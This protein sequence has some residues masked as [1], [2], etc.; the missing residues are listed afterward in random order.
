MCKSPGVEIQIVHLEVREESSVGK[1]GG[2]K[3]GVLCKWLCLPSW[4]YWGYGV[5]TADG[6][7]VMPSWPCLQ[8][9]TVDF[10]C[11]SYEARWFGCVWAGESAPDWEEEAAGTCRRVGTARFLTW[12]RP[13]SKFRSWALWEPRGGGVWATQLK[14]PENLGVEALDLDSG[15]DN[16]NIVLE[17]PLSAALQVTVRNLGGWDKCVWRG[18][19]EKWSFGRGYF[20]RLL[21][22]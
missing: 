3:S 14:L 6:R 1:A 13:N 2:E 15:E 7:S 11:A 8:N 17:L 16:V 21:E 22:A 12:W 19:G 20:F 9:F 5:I 18:G 10:C 4:R